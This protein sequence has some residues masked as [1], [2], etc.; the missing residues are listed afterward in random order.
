MVALRSDALRP[1]PFN[2]RQHWRA[3]SLINKANRSY[4][5]VTFTFDAAF[6]PTVRDSIIPFLPAGTP[7][8]WCFPQGVPFVELNRRGAEPTDIREL[9]F[10]YMEYQVPLDVYVEQHDEAFLQTM[11]E[12]GARRREAGAEDRPVNHTPETR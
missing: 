10:K 7:T 8:R 12:E 5:R 2:E 11:A 4:A 6:M 1:H 9:L 3:I